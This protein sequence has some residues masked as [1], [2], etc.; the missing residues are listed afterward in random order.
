VRCKCGGQCQGVCRAKIK[1]ALAI[2]ILE[3]LCKILASNELKYKCLI[4]KN[5]CI[6]QEL[7]WGRLVYDTE[8]TKGDKHE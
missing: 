1:C 8:N 3:H 2:T 5:S 7:F 4:L 6:S